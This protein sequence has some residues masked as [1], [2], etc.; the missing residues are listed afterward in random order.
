MTSELLFSC[1]LGLVRLATSCLVALL[2]FVLTRV[3]MVEYEV[4]A[5]TVTFIFAWQHLV[6]P[7]GLLVGYFS[8][9]RW[10]FWRRSAF[11]WLGLALSLAVY[12]FFPLWGARLA[13][14][15][16]SAALITLG[17]GLFLVFGAG[18]TISATA[19]NALIVDRL[20]GRQR[21]AALTLVWI[22]TLAGFVVGIS[23]FNQLLKY[24]KI[25]ELTK[26]F[27][28]FAGAAWLLSAAGLHGLEPAAA[29]T[30][31]EA[32][33]VPASDP[34]FLKKLGR[35]PQGWL[36]FGFLALAV[37]FLALQNFLLAPY[38]GEVLAL[39]VAAT[40]RFGIHVTYGTLAGMILAFGLRRHYRR[41]SPKVLLASALVLGILAFNLF[42]LS[43]FGPRPALG[44]L[45]LWLFGLSKGL[46][47]T[48]IS[49]LTMALVH[50]AFGGVFMGLWNLVSGLA[51]AAGE[52]AGGF[53]LD[54]ATDYLGTISLAYGFVFWLASAGLVLCMLLLGL[55]NIEAYWRQLTPRLS[56]PAELHQ[57]NRREE[58]P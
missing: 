58:E 38:G 5:T 21:G 56:L 47:N 37:F 54:Q 49:Y 6:T 52:M 25:V 42:G 33:P 27:L 55:I 28:L 50:P 8:D 31:A 45:G 20:P 16:D 1:R 29:G 48:G 2:T 43:T 26:V 14:S 15:P 13:A 4:P 46:F 11:V 7:L 12:P 23:C 53:F 39:P 41:L 51:L 10:P 24:Y 9:R 17:T 32:G 3:L 30:A 18:T 36:F 35:C 34:G 19:V 22:L 40:A 57:E 44:L